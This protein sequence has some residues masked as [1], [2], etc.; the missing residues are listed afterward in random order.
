VF[1]PLPASEL[2]LVGHWIEGISEFDGFDPATFRRADTLDSTRNRIF[3]VRGWADT[4]FQGW[5]LLLDSAFLD[6]ANRNRL[7]DDPLNSTFGSRF[8]V[9]GQVSRGWGGHR[10][11][12]AVEHESEDFRT[13]G[14]SVFGAPDQDQTRELKAVVGQWRANWLPNLVTDV[15]VRHDE[16]S[17]FADATT[18]RASILFSPSPAWTLHAGYGE[19]IA[20]PEFYD[21]F[22]FFP[23]SFVGNPALRP[24]SSEGWEAGLRWRRG[25]LGVGVTG[26]SNRLTHE[27]VPIVDAATFLPSTGN[28]DGKSRRRG[29]EAEA[30]YRIGNVELAANY[31]FLDA[32]ERKVTGSAAVREIRR[33]KHS[34]NLIATGRWGPLELGGSLAYV[35]KRQDTDF[36]TFETVTLDDYLLASLKVGYRITPALEAYVRAENAFDAD[37]QD[38]IGYNTPGRTI[39]AGLRVRLDR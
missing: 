9:R 36:D 37:Y 24:E 13:A 23:G 28:A 11:T 22:G 4:E 21:L 12:A 32:S 10:F 18:L 35:G 6:S 34:A 16:F 8:T 15:A 2:G 30:S 27:I 17:A 5:S 33:P 14:Q 31:T 3:A 25:R 26:F 1:S 7:G 19:G 20:Q 38:V 39:Y 29:I